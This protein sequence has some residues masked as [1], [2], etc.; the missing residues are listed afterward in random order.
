MK[1]AVISDSHNIENNIRTIK[2]Y[3]SDVDVL[4]HCGD[5]ADDIRLIEEEF[6]GYILLR[7]IAIW[8]RYIQKN[9]S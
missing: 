1:I 7:E 9:W 4:I 2:N 6:T 5:G 8:E 3:L